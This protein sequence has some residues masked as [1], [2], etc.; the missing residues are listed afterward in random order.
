MRLCF[1]GDSLTSGQGDPCKLG[2]PGRVAAAFHRRGIDLTVY[3]LG[4]RGDT[5]TDIAA[6]WYAECHARLPAGAPGAVVFAFGVN[7][8]SE[9]DGQARVPLEQSLA[10]ARR[11]LMQARTLWPCAWIGPA[12]IDEAR[13]PLTL[14]SGETR[15]RSNAVIGAYDEAYRRLAA[16]FGVDYLGLFARLLAADD[17]VRRCLVDGLHPDASGYEAMAALIEQW[18]AFRRLIGADAAAG[19]EG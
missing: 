8:A 15:W 13:Q 11:L 7:D 10:N 18:P 4:V 1:V 6:R 3:N 12:P 9:A 16:E 14:E 17:W 5:S 19:A 2:W